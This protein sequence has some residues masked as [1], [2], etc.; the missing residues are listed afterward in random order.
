VGSALTRGSSLL[1][2][3]GD[4]A[5]VVPAAMQHWQGLTLVRFSAQHKPVRRVRRFVFNLC[6]AM[7]QQSYCILHATENTHCIPQMC[8]R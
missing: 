1:V 3:H 7:T 6:P 2:L 4:P 5:L 8:L